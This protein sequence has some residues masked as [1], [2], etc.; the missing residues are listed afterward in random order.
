MND[1]PSAHRP[2]PAGDLEAHWRPKF[3]ASASKDSDA[4]RNIGHPI[5]HRERLRVFEDLIRRHAPPGISSVLDVGCGSGT[6]FE[7]YRSLGLRVM[8]IDYSQAQIEA[9]RRRDSKAALF[10]G[11]LHEAPAEFQADLAVCIGVIQ[12]VSDPAAFVHALA[13]RVLP[14][15][16]A[17]LSC[18]NARSV[19]PGPYFEKHLRYFSLSAIRQLL[20]QEFD[21]LEVR[22]FYPLPPPVHLLRPLLYRRQTPGLNHGF[23]FALKPR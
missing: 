10:A 19:W 16:M 17:V 13:H 11:L 23:M 18:L 2:Q 20:E 1:L 8:G 7:M 3:E 22:R 5:G 21:I 6:Y 14:G 4:R 12:V 15:G 9:A